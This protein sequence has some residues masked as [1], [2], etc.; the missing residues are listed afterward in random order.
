MPVEIERKF[1]VVSD[2]WRQSIAG[3]RFCQGYLA[4]GHGV[5]VRVRRAGTKAYITIKGKAIGPAR[6]E[7]EYEIP[8]EEAEELLKSLCRRP[9]IEKIRHEVGH[10]GHLWHIDE[11]RGAMPGWCW[12]RSSSPTRRRRSHCRPGSARKSPST[13]ATAT[14]PWPRPSW[15]IARSDQRLA[16]GLFMRRGN[17]GHE[18]LV[19]SRRRRL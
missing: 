2:A 18:R 6:P 9:L 10:A 17:V 15:N 13:R 19:W 4:G 11:F 7:Y 14:P 8:V 12:P 16:A 5:T 1:L 3:Q